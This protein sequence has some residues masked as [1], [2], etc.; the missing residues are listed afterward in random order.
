MP[1]QASGVAAM[2]P[3]RRRWPN[4]GIPRSQRSGAA[5]D[6]PKLGAVAAVPVLERPGSGAK[7]LGYLR[8]GALVARAEAL[9]QGAARRL[10][11]IRPRGFVCAG[12]R[13][14]RSGTPDAGCHEAHLSSGILPYTYARV[15]ERSSSSAIPQRRRGGKQQARKRSARGSSAPET[16]ADRRSGWDSQPT[17]ALFVP[18][19]S[20]RRSRACSSASRSTPEQLAARLRG[21]ARGA[22]RTWRRAKE[23]PGPLAYHEIPPLTGR[24]PPPVRSS[25]VNDGRYAAS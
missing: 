20:S 4:P 6:G 10:Y 16:K 14:H 11:P 12:D 25:M 8:A 5:A 7:Q 21:Q 22:A 18:A 23:K 1:E 15:V 9:Q 13:H 2:K 3:R 19:T 17:G 24:F